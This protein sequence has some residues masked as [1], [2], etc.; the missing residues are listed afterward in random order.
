MIDK[1]YDLGCFMD[2]RLFSSCSFRHTDVASLLNE[3]ISSQ[4]RLQTLKETTDAASYMIHIAN[5][6]LYDTYVV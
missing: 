1:I 6:F 4:L 3:C 5:L 2:I